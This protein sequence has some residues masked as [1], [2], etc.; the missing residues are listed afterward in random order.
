MKGQTYRMAMLFDFFGEVLTERQKEFFHLY[1]N[2]DLS[3]SEIAE[4]FS[5]TRQGVRDVIARAE[6]SLLDLETKTGLVARF[7]T[8]RDQ[9]EDLSKTT[10]ALVELASRSNDKVFNQLVQDLQT[11]VAR[12]Q[13]EE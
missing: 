13:E 10:S 11:N 12:L 5:I 7:H 6:H 3:L 8:T 1:Y 4:R 9:L 2:E